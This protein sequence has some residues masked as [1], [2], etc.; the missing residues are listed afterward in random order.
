VTTGV[1]PDAG[2]LDVKAIMGAHPRSAHVGALSGRP[3]CEG[4]HSVS[5]YWPCET[6]ALTVAVSTLPGVMADC[7]EEGFAK[8]GRLILGLDVG[9]WPP[10]PNPYRAAVDGGTL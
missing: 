4:D 6:W 3:F 10:S 1:E 7:W 8:A 5:T 2:V 9:T